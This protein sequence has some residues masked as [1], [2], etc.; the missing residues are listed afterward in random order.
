[1]AEGFLAKDLEDALGGASDGRRGENGVAGGDEIELFFGM[2]QSVVRDQRGDVGEFS[3]F[4]A[5]KFAARR[6]VEEEIADGDRCA[7]RQRSIFHA[8]NFAAG[9]LDVRARC[10]VAGGRFERD[11]RDGR[12]GGQRLAAKAERGNGEQIVGGAQL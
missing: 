2:G 5:E 11:T 8:M 4:G 6:S 9:D 12:D 1:L 7:A 10:F 3:G